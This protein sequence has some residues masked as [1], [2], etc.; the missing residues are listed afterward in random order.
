MPGS[1]SQAT[2]AY[3][4]ASR[5]VPDGKSPKLTGD[6]DLSIGRNTY[7]DRRSK[8]SSVGRGSEG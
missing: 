1:Q 5:M 6:A 8:G 4:S 2:V 3:S 7:G